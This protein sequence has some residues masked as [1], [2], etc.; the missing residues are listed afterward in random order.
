M[1]VVKVAESVLQNS[2]FPLFPSVKSFIIFTYCLFREP[3]RLFG[4]TQE[5]SFQR[6]A[7][8]FHF[9]GDFVAGA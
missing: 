5:E 6:N 1:V 4:H 9:P 7:A 8:G 3:L 2:S